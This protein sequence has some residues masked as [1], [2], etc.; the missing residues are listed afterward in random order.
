[1]GIRIACVRAASVVFALVVI[2]LG[3]AARADD[4]TTFKV[5]GIVTANDGTPIAGAS[6]V[7]ASQ[8]AVKRAHSDK[9][10]RF[11]FKHVS[12]GTYSLRAAARGYETPSE[13]TVT[14]GVSDV[15]LA[16]VLSPATTNSL[17]VIGQVRA[18][19]RET[20]ST[21]SA[22][23][24]SLSAQ[25]AAAAGATE[26]S[27]MVWQQLSTTPVLPMGGGSNAA[28]VFA[29]R[30][31]DPTETLVD[32]D[33]HQVNNGNTGTFDLSLLD[34]AALQEVQVVYGISP[35][36]L[37][38]PNTIGGGINIVTLQPTIAPHSLL[39]IF[40]GSYGTFGETLQTTGTDGRL[41]YAVSLHA[42]TSSGSVN[43]TIPAGDR[44]QNVGS[45]SSGNS[46]L[47]KLR[48]QLG[49]PSGYGYVQLNFRN[50]TVTRDESAL[51]TTFTPPGFTGTGGG[52]SDALHLANPFASAADSGTFQ[53][54]SGTLLGAHQ[55]NYGLDAQ[56]PLGSETVDGAPATLVKF[57]HLTTLA[58]QSVSGPGTD[59]LPYLY[60][61][62]DLLGDDWLE[63]DHRFGNGLLS[64]KYDLGTETLTT[65]YVQGQG[66]AEAR[67]VG[68]LDAS[69]VWPADA[70]PPVAQ[71]ALSQTQRS[72]VLRYTDDPTSQIHYSLALYQS[73]FSTF[74]SSFDPRA[75]FVWTPSGN[76]AIRASIG[77]TFQAPQLSELIVPPPNARVPVG[78]IIFIG[79]PNLRPDHATDFD[80]GAEQILGG[81][82]TPL[83]LSMDLYQTNLRSPSNQLVVSPIPNCQTP[84]NPTPCPLSYPVNAG[85]G[86]YR[87]IEVRADQLVARDV[88]VRA[89]WSVNS[90]FLTVIPSSIQDGTLVADQQTLGEPLHKAYLE[91]DREPSAGLAFGARLNYEGLYNELNRS[92]YATLDAHVAYRHADYE[93]GLYGTNLTN[94]YSNPFTIVGGGVPYG[95]L[96][97]QPVVTPN[98]FVLQGTAV[99]FVVTKTI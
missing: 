76:T 93:Y 77:T 66:T 41:G 33:G 58:A 29:V 1:M 82:K 61:Q 48:Y 73:D 17:T 21:S 18:S 43:Q 96:P 25:D 88:H 52:G 31:P 47:T 30:G 87:G 32:I 86:I 42:A 57:S 85:N 80:L 90:S 99:N 75:G 68:P 12:G 9:H 26:A 65:D 15:T 50:Q 98:A 34:P 22:P 78:G 40:G 54:F 71:V 79:N 27:S 35:S 91:I 84:S 70:T 44:L 56:V 16:I 8:V 20:V 72:A 95:A 97:G 46:I 24:V 62:R 45:G 13:R 4:D 67:P 23:T 69:V 60:N 59:A 83:Q 19:A 64:F 92:P 7:L 55:S 63:L 74:G 11:E 28:V 5:K 38:G 3:G 53:S 14:I 89:G 51:L 10:G 81:R 49:D 37:I 6:V 36:S 39:R 94:V 2:L